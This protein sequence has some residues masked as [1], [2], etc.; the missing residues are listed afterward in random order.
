MT[1]LQQQE[2]VKSGKQCNGGVEMILFI[3][4]SYD[5]RNIVLHSLEV[6]FFQGVLLLS[7]NTK[8]EVETCPWLLES[9]LSYLQI[10]HKCKG[11]FYTS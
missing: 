5:L 10:I 8:T 11:D 9:T 1:I 7:G 4:T 3:I 2:Y 6:F